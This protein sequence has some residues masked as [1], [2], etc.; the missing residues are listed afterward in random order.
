MALPTITGYTSSAIKA[1]FTILWVPRHFFVGM[2]D[3]WS[4]GAVHLALPP[5]CPE[6]PTLDEQRQ[7]EIA[8]R[9][10]PQLLM[11]RLCNLRRVHESH[12]NVRQLKFPD[13]ETAHNLAAC[14][15]EDPD[16]AQAIAPILRRQEQD[17]HVQ[18]GCD[19]SRAV[20]EV[21][22]RTLHEQK[23]ITISRITEL[24]N[25][26]LRSRGET[27]EYNSA[28]IG[29]K[30]RNLGFYRHRNGSGMILRPSRENSLVSHQLARRLC[31]NLPPVHGCADCVQPEVEVL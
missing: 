30:L 6:L 17:A 3:I 16:I 8:K 29:W 18:R 1:E 28:E 13:T 21:I 7:A 20:V 25:A 26:L 19:V 31:L 14:I 15:Q 4:D 23:E 5:A 27:L 22:W 10:Q 9:F 24:T 11:Y 2:A 12:S